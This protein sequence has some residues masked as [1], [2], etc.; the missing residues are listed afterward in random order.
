MF[1]LVLI[2]T[3]PDS[4][5]LS[6]DSLLALCELLEGSLLNLLIFFDLSK[7]LIKVMLFAF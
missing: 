3:V 7:L 4:S 6:F 1:L 5:L 2:Y